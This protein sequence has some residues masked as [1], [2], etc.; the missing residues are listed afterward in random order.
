MPRPQPGNVCGCMYVCMRTCMC[1][2]MCVRERERKR[3][4]ARER[5][6]EILSVTH[7]RTSRVAC[8]HTSW[9]TFIIAPSKY[10]ELNKPHLLIPQRKCLVFRISH[11]LIF[12]WASLRLLNVTTT[13]THRNVTNSRTHTSSTCRSSACLFERVNLKIDCA[14]TVLFQNPKQKTNELI[15]RFFARVIEGNK[16]VV[17]SLSHEK[18]KS[19]IWDMNFPEK[20]QFKSILPWAWVVLFDICARE[21]FG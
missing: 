16:W 3:E 11:V 9:H 21:K 14:R 1:V 10:Y 20:N 2:C 17:L 5:E 13:V 19:E 15:W 4:K 12:L 6:K 8:V 18:L 7:T